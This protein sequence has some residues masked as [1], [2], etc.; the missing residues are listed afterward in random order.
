MSIGPTFRQSF[1]AMATWDSV[2][3]HYS[4]QI[5]LESRSTAMTHE[6]GRAIGANVGP[7]D[8]V[9]L[10]GTL[11]AG[12]TTL[13]QGIVWGLGSAEYARSPTFVLVNEY[14]ASLP[15]YH[16][17]LYRLDSFEEVDGLGLDDYLYGDGVCVIEWADKA[18]GYFPE[19]NLMIA[20][21]P[22][23]DDERELTIESCLV[24]HLPLF[25]ALKRLG[26]ST[27]GSE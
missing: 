26:A 18:P 17:D 7:G 5:L 13:T 4:M 20:I 8:I 22:I 1:R 3:V 23:S 19:R 27:A 2:Q 21:R 24:E 6:I 25:E 11:G 12:K 15:V 14:R 10:S 9:L 16:M